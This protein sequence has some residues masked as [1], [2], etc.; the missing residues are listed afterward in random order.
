[1]CVCAILTLYERSNVVGLSS[2]E[3]ERS[4]GQTLLPI[5]N[6]S[7][8]ERR[9]S[10]IASSSWMHFVFSLSGDTGYN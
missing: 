9:M 4:R 10:L 8:K 5:P 1:M 3:F 2:Q 6:Y 7:G